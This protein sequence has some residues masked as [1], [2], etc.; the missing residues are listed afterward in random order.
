MDFNT[1]FKYLSLRGSEIYSI[2]IDEFSYITESTF[3]CG[4][5]L[6]LK[7]SAVHHQ[8]GRDSGETYI[9][10]QN[11][12]P[13]QYYATIKGKNRSSLARKIEMDR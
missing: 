2:F 8:V 7:M 13:K 4:T 5:Q 6:L 9:L 3:E 10:N 12:G 11:S 1:Y